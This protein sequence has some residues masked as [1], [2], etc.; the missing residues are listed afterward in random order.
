M[1]NTHHHFD[2]SGGLRTYVSQGTV[3]VATPAN[4]EFYRTVM[5]YPMPRTLQPDR[6]AIFAP[7]NTNNRSPWLMEP[8]HGR[9]V[10]SDGMRTLELH[11]VAGNPHAVGMLMAYL[12]AE[13]ILINADLFT[14]PAPNAPMPAATPSMRNLMTNIRRLKLDVAQHVPLH[15]APGPH[16]ALVKIAGG[17]GQ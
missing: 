1:V 16:E 6:M 4:L 8:V 17:G 7:M 12:P 15:G 3:V 5:L 11:P 2:H 13:K 10:I 14:P 9:Y